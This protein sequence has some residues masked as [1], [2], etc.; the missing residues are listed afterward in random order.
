ME[1]K[2]VSSTNVASVGYDRQTM[3]LEVEFTTGSIY[4]YFDVP[5]QV[6]Q[7]LLNAASVGQFL[8]QQVKHSYRYVQI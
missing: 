2:P 1:R 3:T 8:N 4:Q 6:Y 7:E 5:E